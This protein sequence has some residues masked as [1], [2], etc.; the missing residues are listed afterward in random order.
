MNLKTTIALGVL[1]AAGA[2]LYWWGVNLPPALDP[3]PAPPAAADAGTRAALAELTPDR[4]TRIEVRRGDRVTVLERSGGDWVMP[5]NWP[6]RSAEVRRLVALLGGLRS[7][8]QP[9][10]I[11]DDEDLKKYGLDR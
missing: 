4:L 1:L 3:L 7:R 9:L 5:G 2:V 11:G 8:F 6:T 10:P